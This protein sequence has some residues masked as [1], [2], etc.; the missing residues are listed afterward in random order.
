MV[1]KYIT[2]SLRLSII[3]AMDRHC[4]PFHPKFPLNENGKGGGDGYSSLLGNPKVHYYYYILEICDNRFVFVF[5]RQ[6][7]GMSNKEEEKK[8]RVESLCPWLVFNYLYLIPLPGRWITS[9]K[10]S[11]GGGEICVSRT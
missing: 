3:N 1:S 4:I 11:E 7:I 6:H 2:V 10:R 5:T 8:K 9:E